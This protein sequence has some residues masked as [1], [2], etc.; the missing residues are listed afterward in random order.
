MSNN[1]LE[2]RLKSSFEPALDIESVYTNGKVVL[3]SDEKFLYT[4][5]SED[6]YQLEYGT[7]K[8]VSTF[9]GDSEIVTA[10][11]VAPS[12]IY[13]ASA[14]R[15]MQIRIWN[16]AE[17]TVFRSFKGHQAPVITMEFD[18]SST[19]VASGASDS[20]IKVWD[21]KRGYCTHNLRGNKGVITCLK[22]KSIGNTIY[23]ASGSE[24]GSIRIYNL[25]TSKCE[26]VLSEH[27]S[28]VREIAFSK[29]GSIFIS[30]ARD[31]VIN[32]W[33]TKS[34]SLMHTIPVFEA[35]ESV[36]MYESSSSSNAPSDANNTKIAFIGGERGCLRAF[37]VLTAKEI[38]LD[39]PS[40]SSEHIL[41][42]VILAPT[43]QELVTV[44]SDQIIE[45]Y[46]I[47]TQLDSK[48]DKLSG[49]NSQNINVNKKW[50]V[51]GY[52]DEVID[53]SFLGS[54]ESYL[55]VAVN[56]EQ[57]R[58]YDTSTLTCSLVDAHS[59]ILLS[60]DVHCSRDLLVTGSKD[61][62][63]KVWK[64]Q[65]NK[66]GDDTSPI[67]SLVGTA[68]GHTGSIGA[69][70]FSKD[71]PCTFMV[72]GGQDRTIKAWNL[73]ELSESKGNLTLKT[74]FTIKAHDKDINALAV[75]PNSKLIASTSQDRTVKLWDATNGALIR[76]FTGH[77][78]GVWAVEF[79][80]IDTVCA[81]SSADGTIR[82]W[83]IN[84]GSCLKTFE[85]HSGSPL[86][87]K[88]ISSG[89]QLLS[90][91]SDGLIKLWNIKSNEC[92]L[93]LDKHDDKVWSIAV[94]SDESSFVSG[95]SDSKIIF[96][97]D[98]TQEQLDK[99]HEKESENLLMSQALE[100]YLHQKDYKNSI[101]LALSLDKP[102]TLTKLFTKTMKLSENNS[103]SYLGMPEVDKVLS[104]LSKDQLSKLLSYVRE[105][106]TN[107]RFSTIAQAVLRCI[108]GSYSSEYLLSIPSIRGHITSLIPYTERHLSRID[109]LLTDSYILD[110]ALHS[111]DSYLPPEEDL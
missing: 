101:F 29:D 54:D 31:S 1:N 32:V 38:H 106:N 16:L 77:K 41:T 67:V 10:F 95:S 18:E 89:L 22:F 80:P 90:S 110:F 51:V 91:G 58:I 34:K 19:L 96:W 3:S 17:K 88:F 48:D 46:S 36:S 87:V 84:D 30:V 75:S 56:S 23:L 108:F 103:S 45:A 111:L 8:K 93:T 107:S 98:T 5:F 92:D 70:K 63:A 4:T 61:N 73:N 11:C 99:L 27:V 59:D 49:T 71:D 83:N 79:S 15:S 102:Y 72:T 14:S 21:I 69:V 47:S 26:A 7:A 100:N 94:K 55:A 20:S 81:T 50:Q 6:I 43:R 82:I 42:Q 109:K 35:I 53:V 9:P 24:D 62:T 40:S 65:P 37:N 78:R 28:V 76:T 105:W 64:F 12:Q 57:L 44:A 13:L 104:E 66:N 25:N 60:L 52:N 74:R 85:G 97:R 68:T 86:S 39:I 33:N 2:I